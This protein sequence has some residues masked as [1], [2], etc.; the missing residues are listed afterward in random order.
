[1]ENA[2]MHTKRIRGFLPE[3]GKVGIICI[4]EKQF[5]NMELF[6]G[7]KNSELPRIEQQLELF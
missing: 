6:V 1:M 5:D 4:T 7:R 3:Y 2:K